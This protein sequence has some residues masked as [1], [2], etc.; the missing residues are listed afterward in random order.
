MTA[1]SEEA[2]M[3]KRAHWPMWLGASYAALVGAALRGS[4]VRPFSLD[5]LGSAGDSV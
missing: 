5:N 2:E 4:G 1:L 3:A